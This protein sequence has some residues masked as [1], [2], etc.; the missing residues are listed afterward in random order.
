M[1]LMA[2]VRVR[3]QL[4]SGERC[5]F[6]LPGTAT[7][8]EL[9]DR[10]KAELRVAKSW[11][12]LLVGAVRARSGETLSRYCSAAGLLEVAL[13]VS[14][15]ACHCCGSDASCRRCS[16]CDDAYYCSAACQRSHWR[17]HRPTCRGRLADELG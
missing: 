13:V 17:A 5:D 1:S 14:R 7:F 15:P 3:V 8:W 6:L 16:G 2:L 9:R 10:I 11:Q 12:K 4:L